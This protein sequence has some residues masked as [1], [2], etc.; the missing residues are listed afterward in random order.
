MK[1]TSRLRDWIAVLGSAAN[2][3]E[4]QLFAGYQVG[5]AIAEN[6]KNLLH[7]AT[8]GIP[9]AAALGAKLGGACVIGI[10]PADDV[11]DHLNR[12]EKPIANCDLSFIRAWAGYAIRYLS[13]LV[14]A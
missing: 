11:G 13:V 6:R 8:T 2:C 9:Y 12:F 4:R 3:H 5:R 7:G 14:R 1:L 10:S